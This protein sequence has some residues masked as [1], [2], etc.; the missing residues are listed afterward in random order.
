MASRRY[1]SR[2]VTSKAPING[3]TSVPLPPTS[4]MMIML[5]MNAKR[6]ISGPTKEM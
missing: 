5:T 2:K 6:N 3:P 1:S 4:T